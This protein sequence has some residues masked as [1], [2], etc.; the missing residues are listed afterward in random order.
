MNIQRFPAEFKEE[1]VRQ[2]VERG[3]GVVNVV[4]RLGSI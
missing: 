2:I 3:H 1:A 4:N